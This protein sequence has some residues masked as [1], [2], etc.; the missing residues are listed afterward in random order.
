[1]F[2]TYTGDTMGLLHDENYR[3]YR[4]TRRDCKVLFSVTRKGKAANCHVASDK[5]GLRMLKQAINEFTRFIFQTYP[6][7]D[8]ILAQAKKD[9]VIRILLK[10][11][12]EI[13]YTEPDITV[14]ARR[15]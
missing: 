11:G 8:M 1:M 15:Y 12:F 4:W 2:G 13:V 7:C 3:I 9:S 6:W 10:L 5:A 14:L